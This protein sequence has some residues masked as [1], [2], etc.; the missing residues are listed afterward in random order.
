MKLRTLGILAGAGFAAY[1]DL[2]IIAVLAMAGQRDTWTIHGMWKILSVA[3]PFSVAPWAILLA[4][5]IV[6]RPR[7]RKRA[8]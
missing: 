8:P 6:T 5:V 4:I 7:R 2:A 3:W 1:W